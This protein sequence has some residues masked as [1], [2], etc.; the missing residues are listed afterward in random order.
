[1]LQGYVCGLVRKYSHK[2]VQLLT[3]NPFRVIPDRFA[4]CGHREFKIIVFLEI[5][6]KFWGDRFDLKSHGHTTE[7]WVIRGQFDQGLAHHSFWGKFRHLVSPRILN[8]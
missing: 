3:G 8:S 7:E 4:I 2:I 1:M 6:R 5:R